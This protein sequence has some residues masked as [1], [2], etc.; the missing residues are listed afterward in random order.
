VKKLFIILILCSILISAAPAAA[1]NG[2]NLIAIGPV[3]RSMG[4]VGIVA[5]QDAITSVFANPAAMGF[6]PY[7]PGSQFNFA[8]TLFM[9]KVS[10]KVIRT[11]GTE[12]ADSTSNVFAVPAIGLSVPMS[13]T[14]PLRFGLAAYGVSGLG[15][16]YR[17][18]QLD[19]GAG[20]DFGG[21]M[22]AP[23]I[24]GEY[25]QLQIMKFAPAV[26]YRPSDRLS[27]GLALHADY[28]TLDLRSGTSINYGYGV[29]AGMVY[30]LIENISV[31][32]TYMT[33]QK[34]E[35]KDVLDF[36]GDGTLDTLKLEAP[37]E[38]GFGIAYQNPAFNNL[39]VET[40]VKWINWAAA[41]GYDDFDWDDQWVMA[42]GIQV[43]PVKNLFLRAGYNYGK[44]PV[45]EHN[46]FDGSF[47]PLG[48]PNSINEVQG[49]VLPSYYYET[50]RI[51]GFPAIVQS[52]LTVGIGYDVTPAFGVHA[53]YMHAFEEKM[54]EK[55]MDLF[56]QPVT[57]ESTLSEDSLDVGFTWKF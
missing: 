20:Y 35:Y 26:S 10:G 12:S 7:G 21:G 19:N 48:M 23:L 2:D 43:E 42:I 46:G 44:N 34:V 55:G 57:L 50:F 40:N 47:S 27:L 13:A 54:S 53:G 25:T 24:A 6:A 31:G 30:K 41:D 51:L 52:H 4:G 5:P 36:D 37:Q 28:S 11:S 14:I 32:V 49:K 38:L 33:G 9:P 22:T 8:G 18:T 56:G 15:V 16:D 3:A 1:T 29:K 39:L 17:G 45:A